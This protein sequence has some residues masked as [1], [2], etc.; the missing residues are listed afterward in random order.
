MKKLDELE[1]EELISLIYNALPMI[2]INEE[3]LECAVCGKTDKAQYYYICSDCSK[4]L[5][6]DKLAEDD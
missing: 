5:A 1:R 3:C 4:L 2:R 6:E